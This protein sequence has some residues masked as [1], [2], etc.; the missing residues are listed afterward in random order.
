MNELEILKQ[1]IDKLEESLSFSSKLPLALDQALVGRGFTKNALS[2][3][4]TLT[5]PNGGTGVVTIP[6]GEILK[7][8]GTSAITTINPLSGNNTY[9][10]AATSGGATTTGLNFTD[11]ILVSVS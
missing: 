9:W 2:S 11:G 7:G 4:G 1:R 3:G 6:S 10:V 5:V 8:A